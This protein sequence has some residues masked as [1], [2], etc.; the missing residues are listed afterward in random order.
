MESS[1]AATVKPKKPTLIKIPYYII[2]KGTAGTDRDAVVERVLP[3]IFGK[4]SYNVICKNP[5]IQEEL[6]KNRWIEAELRFLHTCPEYMQ[7]SY[8][9]RLTDYVAHS[10]NYTRRL[11]V[12][13]VM[14]KPDDFAAARRWMQ[15]EMKKRGL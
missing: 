1:A 6:R 15:K 2:T 11:V 14:P 4:R 9:Q 7:T 13:K 12:F 8:F 10:S 5:E 3:L